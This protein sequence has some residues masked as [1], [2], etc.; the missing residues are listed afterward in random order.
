M[1]GA[2]KP[3]EPRLAI[4]VQVPGKSE[5]DEDS[6]HSE[7]SNAQFIEQLM[8]DSQPQQPPSPNPPNSKKKAKAEK[9]EAR[10]VE[11]KK[12]KSEAKKE[13]AEA[14]KAKA[15]EQELKTEAKEAKVE[16]KKA[17]VESNGEEE[18]PSLVNKTNALLES[19][20]RCM[21]LE[22]DFLTQIQLLR[23]IWPVS[24]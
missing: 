1:T 2:A 9:A 13:K 16:S 23:K 11:A 19:E 10:K 15:Q 21:C 12:A 8:L 7:D 14:K 18:Q 24:V 22:C 4:K 3:E 6:Q 20:S 5:S 17:K